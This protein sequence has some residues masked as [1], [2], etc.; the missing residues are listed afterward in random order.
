MPSTRVLAQRPGHWLVTVYP[1][2]NDYL[3]NQ[4][5]WRGST[6]CL[7]N[8]YF[9]SILDSDGIAYQYDPN[10][11]SDIELTRD[12]T[13]NTQSIQIKM[14]PNISP[15]KNLHDYDM[16]SGFGEICWVDENSTGD[17]I[18][19]LWGNRDVWLFGP[20]SD[21]EY[22]LETEPIS[23]KIQQTS[24]TDKGTIYPSNSVINT[25]KFLDVSDTGDIDIDD[26]PLASNASGLLPPIPIYSSKSNLNTSTTLKTPL[27]CVKNDVN[28]VSP[29]TNYVP[30]RFLISYEDIHTYLTSGGDGSA[31]SVFLNSDGVSTFFEPDTDMG[32]VLTDFDDLGNQYSYFNQQKQ[33]NLISGVT[34][35]NG[36]TT[37]TTTTSRFSKLQ[38]GDQIKANSHTDDMYV[39]I[40]SIESNISLTLYSAYQGASI[41][42][43]T[44]DV[45]K[46]VSNIAYTGYVNSV[47][48]SSTVDGSRT[49]DDFVDFLV[50]LLERSK[51]S[52]SFDRGSLLSLKSKLNGWIPT[53]LIN[54]DSPPLDYINNNVLPLLPIVPYLKA[55][56]LKILWDGIYSAEESVTTI[57]LTDKSIGLY[58]TETISST[59]IEQIYNNI[60]I[61]YAWSV[62]NQKYYNTISVGSKQVPLDSS[63]YS[64]DYKNRSRYANTRAI[65]SQY[66]YEDINSSNSPN[67]RN[68]SID[69]STIHEFNTAML[70]ANNLLYRNAETRKTIE[71]TGFSFWRW[72]EPGDIIT[73]EE[74]EVLPASFARVMSMT[75]NSF[76][77]VK[78]TVETL[79][80]I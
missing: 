14:Y 27:I 23:F 80:A 66:T 7:S 36:L 2:K 45:Y 48:I 57:D 49:I 73:I 30:R 70:V 55:G 46:T 11:V 33:A 61:S 58:R 19:Q 3:I 5:A 32:S 41:G 22:G 51:L 77:D 20:M 43:T 78:M 31:G 13:L 4:N 60:N 37:V 6:S 47:G 9:I 72:L 38:V 75:R 12:L 1:S 16:S 17:G 68:L 74:D 24:L 59:P 10:I 50:F 29:G 63:S 44:M 71:L 65:T 39:K 54:E 21:F 35:T 34:F 62:I 18:E 56:N 28:A 52:V 25:S 42:P 40:A 79:P 67:A 26:T 53:V 69:A 64:Y 76:G 8:G 15:N